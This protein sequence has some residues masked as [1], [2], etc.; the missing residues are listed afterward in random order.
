LDFL[1][2]LNAVDPFPT[3]WSPITCSGNVLVKEL[4]ELVK[5][6]YPG[7]A[8][9]VSVVPI[10]ISNETKKV[11]FL[12]PSPEQEINGKSVLLLDT[13]IHTGSTMRGAVA[14]IVK[15]GAIDACAYSLMVKCDSSFIPTM[16]GFMID[17]T[18]SLTNPCALKTSGI[19]QWSALCCTDWP[20]LFLPCRR[21]NRHFTPLMAAWTPSSIRR[22]LLPSG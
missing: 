6:H 3:I 14:E 13:A 12:T 22:S 11:H 15:M 16:W 4:L 2:R 19:F 5:A 1:E 9:R 10:G 20:T 18:D 17:K 21:L 8:S 7:W